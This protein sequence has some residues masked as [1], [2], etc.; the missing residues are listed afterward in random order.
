MLK[1]VDYLLKDKEEKTREEAESECVKTVVKFLTSATAKT[2]PSAT[3][4]RA[5]GCCC[6][7]RFYS[8]TT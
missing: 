1:V 7:P 2:I 6:V 5:T 3:P 8:R 4:R